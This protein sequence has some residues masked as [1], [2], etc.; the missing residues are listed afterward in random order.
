M[1]GTRIDNIADAPNPYKSSASPV[2]NVKIAF[3]QNISTIILV[4]ISNDDFTQPPYIGAN[5]SDG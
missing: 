1:I 4:K 3:R 5:V 2:A